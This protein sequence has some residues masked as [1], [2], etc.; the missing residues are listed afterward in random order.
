[1]PG[2]RIETTTSRTAELTCV[3]RAASFLESNPHYHSEDGLAVRLL[4]GFFKTAVHFPPFRKLFVRAFAPAGIYEYVIARTK[5][6]DA[7]FAQALE[8]GFDQVLLFGAGFDTR[9]VRFQAAGRETK[10]FELDVP[11]TQKA[12]LGQYARRGIGVPP[13]LTLIAIDFDRQPLPEA[14]LQAGFARG[15]RSLFVMEGLLMYLQPG[16]V[17]AT[18]RT[19]QEFAGPGSEVVFDYVLAGV[20]RGTAGAY[21]EQGIM[22]TVSK[23]GERWQFGMEPGGVASFLE[24]YGFSL[25]EQV[26]PAELE[27]RYFTDDAGRP[28]GRVN[29]T[30]VLVRAQK[31][32]GASSAA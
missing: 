10:V 26:D 24:G 9:A 7:A 20:L 29:G 13:N 5:Y 15:S 16:S 6:I 30:H 22:E 23:A 11:I 1:M 19:V 14:L 2:R 4:P 18:F 32:N 3:S 28:V 27:R 17:Q 12:K 25:L 21:G 8:R 31:R